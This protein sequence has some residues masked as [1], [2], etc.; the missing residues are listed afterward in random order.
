MN[1]DTAPRSDSTP[2]L[3]HDVAVKLFTADNPRHHLDIDQSHGRTVH[4]QI[5]TTDAEG[6]DFPHAAQ[7]F[8]IRRDVFDH[9]GQRIS[10]EI[11]HG[12]TSLGLHEATA[13]AIA[14]W[15]RQHWAIENRIHWVR[16]VVFAED[17]Q[18]SYLGAT[19]HAMAHSATSR[20]V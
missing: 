15:V 18:N 7:V 10:K 17:H 20:S 16:D 1:A 5:W 19:A 2:S 9:T 13:E 14:R 6:I 8:K 11:V 3:L 12:I 4:R